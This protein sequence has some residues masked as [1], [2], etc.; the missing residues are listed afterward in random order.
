M[1]ENENI[2]IEEVEEAPKTNWKKE[3]LDWIVSIAVAVVIALVIRNFVFTLVEVDGQS[4]HPTLENGDRLFTRILAYNTPKQGDIVIF[5]PPVSEE[6][7]SPNKKVAYVKRVIAV[8]GQVVD[9]SPEGE[10]TVDGKTLK[11]DYIS[12][13]INT[14]LYYNNPMEFP[15]E[16][17]KGTIFVLGDNRNASHDSRSRDVGAVP[18]DNIIG[19]AQ[20]RLWPFDEIG[21]LY[22]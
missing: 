22:K 3:A 18:L 21:S 13:T 8:E 10:V 2:V 7:R 4:M 11:E 16:V 1:E 19:K 6:D 20:V 15:Y 5:N 9:I 12:E 14:H 17:P